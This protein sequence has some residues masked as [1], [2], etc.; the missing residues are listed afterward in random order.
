MNWKEFFKYD[1][2]KVGLTAMFF[3]LASFSFVYLLSLSEIR[4]IS[5][6]ETY[7][8]YPI[9]LFL[10]WPF[11][12]IVSI[13]LWMNIYYHASFYVEV[14][15]FILSIFWWYF[16]SCLVIW[17]KDKAKKKQK[18]IFAFSMIVVTLALFAIIRLQTCSHACPELCLVCSYEENMDLSSCGNISS[19]GGKCYYSCIVLNSRTCECDYSPPCIYP[20]VFADLAEY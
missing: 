6:I 18:L 10:S 2:R 17:V 13:F 8:F 15:G 20:I 16:L 3:G 7:I 9:E 11:T 14:M 5:I 4:R 12:L 19:Q 1:W